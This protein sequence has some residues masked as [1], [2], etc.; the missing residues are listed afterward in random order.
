M[1]NKTKK[2]VG[3]FQTEQEA[4]RAIEQLQDRGY[5]NSEIS[6]ITRSKDDMRAI[7]SETGTKAP[8]GVAAGAA[9]GGVLGG[10]A[11]LFAGI[12]A[13]AIPGIG[14]ILAAGPIAA[15][16]TGAAVGAGAGGLVG[17][18]VGLGIPEDEAEEYERNVDEGHILVLV[19][20]KGTD[21]EIHGIFR[22]NRSLNADR[23]RDYEEENNLPGPDRVARD[24]VEEEAIKTNMDR[25]IR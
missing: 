19:D 3:V 13:L 16:L 5:H 14:P 2:V 7:E 9:T 25:T 10:L 23:Y 21:R 8:E 4:A 20:Q 24:R 12:G 11:G 18:L 22:D 6:V 15:T 17:G 1:A